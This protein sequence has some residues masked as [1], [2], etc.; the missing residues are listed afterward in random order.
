MKKNYRISKSNGLKTLAFSMLL[1][2][3]IELSAQ[4]VSNFETL[5]LPA[6]SFWDGA[7][8]T[9]SFTCG[10]AR[11]Y[12]TYDTVSKYWLGDWA[13]TNMKND[14]VGGYTNMYSTITAS[15]VN[16]SN[17]YAVGNNIA[18]VSLLNTT[19]GS[20][21]N[22]V[23][24]TNTTLVDSSLTYGDNMGKKFG[25]TNGNDPDWFKVSIFGFLNHTKTDSID[26]YLADYRFSDNSQDYIINKWK[27][28]DLSPLKN[29]DSLVFQLS[30][31]DT[32][33]FGMNTPA[34]FAIDNFNSSA[35]VGI[36]KQYASNNGINLFPNPASNILY[37]TVQD[38]KV[39]ELTITDF[40]GKIVRTYQYSNQAL[41][42]INVSDLEKGFYLVSLKTNEGIITKKFVKN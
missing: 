14:S 9:G 26:F 2:F 1:G 28:V 10:D 6:D 3:G 17:N 24:I 20:V 30:S 37:L 8:L 41:Y 12:N 38:V 7:D 15:G 31:S 33:F 13:Y 27:W 29:I 18:S 5:S 4:T 25:G 32:G 21:L 11:F 36:Q 40:S 19:K 35:P 16:G 42:D 39:N 23:Y 22:G 34:F